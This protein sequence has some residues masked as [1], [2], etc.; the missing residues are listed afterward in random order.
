MRVHYAR[1]NDFGARTTRAPLADKGDKFGESG[2]M[3]HRIGVR[4]P[5]APDAFEY[6]FSV[7]RI[8]FVPRCA[9]R[10]DGEFV[11]VA[12]ST[13]RS[14]RAAWKKRPLKPYLAFAMHII[15]GQP[16]FTIGKNGTGS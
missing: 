15:L 11:N 4:C 2:G 3:S 13:L 7:N 8:R 5:L 12:F 9:V 1:S 14:F 16:A 10:V 6:L